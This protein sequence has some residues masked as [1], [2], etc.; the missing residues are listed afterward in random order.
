MQT[1]RIRLMMSLI[2]DNAKYY[3][4]AI[5][6][7]VFTV[8][9]GL[10]T[11]LI[12]AETVD[13]II[14]TEPLNAPDFIA[15]AFESIGGREYV[16]K[17]LW[18]MALI[19]IGASLVRSVFLYVR[20][21]ATAQAAEQAALD[22][23]QRLYGH[24]QRLTYNYHVKAE[25][26]DLIQRC[27]SDV[28]TTRRFLASQ[29]IEA[30]NSFLMIVFAIIILLGRSVSL[31]LISTWMVIPLFLFAFLFFKL[32]IKNF[33]I[34]DEAEGK[35]S[36]VLQENLTG[37]RVVRAFGRQRFEVEKFDEKSAD[38]RDKNDK[39]MW[40]LAIYWSTSDIMTMIQTCIMLLASVVYAS[41]G[42]ITIG[43]VTIFISYIGMILW[44]VR[45]LGRILSDAGKALVSLERIDEI[46]CQ[47]PEAEEPAATKP[48][49][50]G[51]I[52]FDN[53][54]FSYEE[55]RPVLQNVSFTAKA[56]ETI[57]ILGSTGCGKS[58]LVHLLQRLYEPTSG[59]ITIGGAP[60]S[61]VEKHYLRSHIGLVLQEPFLYSKSIRDN[62]GIALR[63]RTDDEIYE[64]A[65]VAQADEFI[66]ESEKGYETLVGERG[67]TLS[68]GQKQRVAIAR[69]LLKENNVLIFDDS[70]SAVDT[71]T[72]A[73]IRAELSKKRQG[74]T[75][76]I[77]SHRITT[78]AE[79]DRILVLDQGTIV[80]QGTHQDL[81]D[82]PGLYQRI[83][84]IQSAIEEEFEEET[85][86]V[87][88]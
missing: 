33:R 56:G 41:Q 77:I 74:V 84:H 39:L 35:M 52:V 58:T 14:G 20:G 5:I 65:R 16:G 80:Q 31:T 50:S 28:E 30:I 67:V 37:V 81:I 7:T 62:V 6:S 4:R 82:Q 23:R 36:A 26:G 27:T 21:R 60:L 64:V 73:A 72:D 54:S 79:A 83:Y 1:R 17:N 59:R 61:T 11:P 86:A 45:Q 51:D 18:I 47:P 22:L 34:S 15:R 10:L 24:L 46:L 2:R 42:T 57:A 75:T 48:D 68:G 76:F 29:L 44:P 32:V 40:L 69:T 87:M 70:L 63:D 8:L 55:A 19:L 78:L 66:R 85:S 3:V 53:V 9:I 25:T 43:T 88:A 38:L 71:Q 13:A 12:M 49:L